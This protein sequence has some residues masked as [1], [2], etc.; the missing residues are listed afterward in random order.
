MLFGTI[1]GG[2]EEALQNGRYDIAVIVEGPESDVVIRR[3]E[4]SVGIWVNGAS[5]SFERV[6]SFYSMATN[7][8]LVEIAE[9]VVLKEHGL[10][11]DNLKIKTIDK[12][13]NTSDE[14]AEFRNSLGRLKA[15]QGLAPSRPDGVK[16]LRPNLFRARL[17]VP[18]NV[19]IGRHTAR[20]YLF[21]SGEF[22]AKKSA[23]LVVRKT[24]FEQWAYNFA[25]KQSFLHGILAVLVAI[26]TGWLASVVFRKD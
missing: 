15:A 5:R 20:A 16:F 23:R 25:H 6:P 2:Q 9:P 10:G 12:S 22:I 17:A 18:A 8:P 1:E 7:R 13:T 14:D 24:G 21:R 4:R 3:K 19:P 26:A 11:Y